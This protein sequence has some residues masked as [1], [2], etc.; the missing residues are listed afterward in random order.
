MINKVFQGVAFLS[1]AVWTLRL[2]SDDALN[3]YSDLQ[4]Q[5]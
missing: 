4:A 2:I 1:P 5:G 3:K